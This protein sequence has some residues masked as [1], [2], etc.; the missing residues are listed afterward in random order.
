MGREIS[1][2]QFERRD[3]VRFSTALERETALLGDWLSAGRCDASP[4]IVGFELEAWLLDHAALPYPVNDEFLQR[5]ASPLVVPELSKFNVELNGTPQPLRAGAF[6]RLEDELAA[7]WQRCLS[8]AHEMDGT[9]L[10]IGILPTIRA[11][12][13]TLANISPRN[14][15]YALNEQVLKARGGRPLRIRIDGRESLAL[16]HNDVML[17]AATTSFQVHLQVPAPQLSRYHNASAVLSAPLVAIAANSPFLF[18]RDLWDE[19]RI[20]LFEQSVDVGE[21]DQDYLHRVT[22]GSGYVKTPLEVFE[23]NLRAFPVL[24]PSRFDEGPERMA[25]LCLHN[26]TIWRWNRLL[27]GFDARREP[28]LRIEHRVMAAGPTIIDMIANA[29]LYIGAV[30]FLA[31]RPRPPEADIDFGTAHENFYRAARHGLLA[32]LTWSGGRCVDARSLL[33]EEIVPMAAEGLARLG[34]AA[35]ERAR[36]LDVITLRARTGQNGA[37]WQREHAARHDRDLNKLVADYLEHQRRG[38]PVHEWEL[39]C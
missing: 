22:F 37:D 23:E 3:F 11:R 17:E 10:A 27:V 1:K 35:D 18:G 14:R 30:H 25:H 16:E 7:T 28:H 34:I 33:L 8:V 9:L 2:T 31:Q 36:Y 24:L 15:Y 4:L 21:T 39:E 19:T 20:A 6:R 29:A 32:E 5:L 26:G 13:L 12:D 38:A